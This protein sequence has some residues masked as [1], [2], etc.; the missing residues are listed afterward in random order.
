MHCLVTGDAQSTIAA[1]YRICK[2]SVYR[3]VTE[4]INVLWDVLK[5]N[6]L[7]VPQTEEEWIYIVNQFEAKWSF[8]NCIGAIDG[9]HIIM[10]APARSGS[11]YFTYKKTHSIVLLA[12]VNANYEYMMVISVLKE[13]RVMVAFLL[14]ATWDMQWIRTY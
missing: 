13:D 10:Q 7:K 9:K 1:S 14:I 11:C 5:D 8:G 12:V 3:I 4:T 2:A 6:F